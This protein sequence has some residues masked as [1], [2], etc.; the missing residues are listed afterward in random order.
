MGMEKES[1]TIKIPSHSD[2][3]RSIYVAVRPLFLMASIL[4]QVLSSPAQ[5]SASCPQFP[6]TLK[7]PT[8]K[9]H[10]S[11][12]CMG[13]GTS[14]LTLASNQ[15]LYLCKNGVT[16]A[17]YPVSVG[18]YGFG[19]TTQGDN[20]TPLGTYDLR[21]PEPSP[22]FGT[23]IYVNYPNAEQ[24]R[25]GF[26]GPDGKRRQ[27]SGSDILIH[28]PPVSDRVLHPFLSQLPESLQNLAAKAIISIGFVSFNWTAGCIAVG[29]QDEMTEIANFARAHSG[30][31]LT[32][33]D[34]RPGCEETKPLSESSSNADLLTRSNISQR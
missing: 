12:P 7:P 16:F 14:I 18:K 6:W 5:A 11:D 28:G 21:K 20:K 9:A 17:T 27:Y 4:M 26:V 25:S 10:P 1:E 23:R 13:R 33:V 3:L 34:D 31:T 32:V 24:K 19:K 8:R 29:T 22:N 30:L 15:T 2:Q